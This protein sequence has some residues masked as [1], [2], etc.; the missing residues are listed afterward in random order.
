MLTISNLSD[1][2]NIPATLVHTTNL[3]FQH[4]IGTKGPIS[5]AS[6]VINYIPDHNSYYFHTSYIKSC[7][8]KNNLAT[9]QT[10]N[11]IYQFNLEIPV[12]DCNISINT[13]ELESKLKAF[14][15]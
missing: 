7:E 8:I 11:S 5:Y 9:F 12:A 15:L 10:R 1:I 4:L 6:N 13:D 14:G 3:A 2:Q